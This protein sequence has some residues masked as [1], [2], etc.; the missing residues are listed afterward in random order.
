MAAQKLLQEDIEGQVFRVHR[1]A[2]T[3]PDVLELERQR[4]FDRC[5]LY[6]GHETE[7]PNA[8]DYKRR[9]VGGR[10]LFFV[11]ASDGR[12]RVFYNTCR[13]RGAMVCRHDQGNGEIFQCFYHAWTFNSRGD[14]VGVPD[15]E[16]YSAGFNKADFSL[17]SPPKVDSYRGFIFVCYDPQAMD[18][19]SYL[20]GATEFIDLVADQSEA[21]MRVIPGSNR[22]SIKANWKLL[23]ENS[24]DNYHVGPTHK[25]YIDYQTSLG[26]KIL[27]QSE[28]WS[29][30]YSLGNGHA[31]MEFAATAGRPTARWSPLFGE[32]TKDE[33]AA[34]RAHLV[35]RHGEERTVRMADRSRNLLIYPNLFI[36][37]V[38]GLTLRTFWPVSHEEIEIQA[39]EM[40]PSEDEEQLLR[41]RLDSFLT[42]L[43][44][45]GFATPDDSEALETC[46]AGFAASEVEWS[47]VSR[48]MHIEHPQSIHELQLRTFWR[49]WHA[50][51]Q[52]E[53]GQGK[54]W[55]SPGNP[56]AAARNASVLVA[57]DD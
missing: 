3:S 7:V 22:Y 47:D 8:G 30:A 19:A 55:L 57:A 50:Q 28:R 54:G 43:G 10:P 16:G 41:R 2:M 39:W 49:Q 9:K 33:I 53:D 17:L 6:L 18:L 13:H 14:L 15:E 36:I 21:G 56:E 38:A 1:S 34:L 46:Q 24:F 32:D 29:E 20:A 45:G 27:P 5:W 40:V 11:R 25:T 4:V 37:D 26:V 52:S 31:V 35:E 12:V 44:P 23:V 48:G 51:L 42:F